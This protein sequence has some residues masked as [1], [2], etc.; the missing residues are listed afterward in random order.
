MCTEKNGCKNGAQCLTC[1]ILCV[2]VINFRTLQQLRR[3]RRVKLWLHFE[4]LHLLFLLLAAAVVVMMMGRMREREREARKRDAVKT[5]S[6][7]PG[8]HF[9]CSRS[10]QTAATS[11]SSRRHHH[12]YHR[13]RI[14]SRLALKYKLIHCPLSIDG[15]AG[16]ASA[17]LP[18]SLSR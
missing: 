15:G 2:C 11:T 7:V 18:S 9:G 5:T 16:S 6:V 14:C 4:F 10:S 3:R 13:R 1:N 17:C 8:R 12:Y